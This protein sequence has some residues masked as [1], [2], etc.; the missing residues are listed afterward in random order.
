MPY[1]HNGAV[2]T[3]AKLTA[4]SAVKLREEAE[5][6]ASDE[7]P[8]PS[9][10][11]TEEATTVEKEE[12]NTLPADYSEPPSFLQDDT[13]TYSGTTFG[14]LMHKAMEMIDFTTLEPTEAAIRTRIQEL[15]AKNVFTEEETKTLLS[16]RRNRNPVQGIRTFMESPLCQA[17]K[18][19]TVIR[20]EMPFSILLPAHSF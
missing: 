1:S 6:A 2:H 12:E 11:L 14:T 15:A 5:Y 8:Y 9:V 16:H 18:E 7:P 19:S 3:P 13:P 20:K 17:M 4:T 10:T